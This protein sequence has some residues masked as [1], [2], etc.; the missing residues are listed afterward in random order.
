[1]PDPLPKVD[2][3]IK[4]FIRQRCLR[5]L[6]SSISEYYPG[7]PVN[8]A[9]DSKIDDET[10]AYYAGLE[11]RGDRVLLLP[12]NVGISAGRNALVDITSRP[13][14]LFL[15]DDVVFFDETR[16]RDMVDVLDADPS[17]GVAGGSL[18]DNGTDLLPYEHNV[19]L[20]DRV[21]HYYPVGP[22]STVIG[23]HPCR[24]ADVVH[25]FCL[26]RRQVFDSTR[27]DEELKMAE[28]T[29]FF[30]RLKAAGWKAVHVGG[31]SVGHFRE[32]P[33]GYE[34]FRFDP[35]NVKR[36]MAKWHM[37]G[38][39]YHTG[40]VG[41]DRHEVRRLYAKS[42]LASLREHRLGEAA[43]TLTSALVAEAR[44]VAAGPSAK[45]Q[46]RSA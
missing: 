14:L 38:S 43:G 3:C 45:G 17:I 27:W 21:L 28:H 34:N 20:K 35:E 22:E 24:W 8:I 15:D 33:E 46:R 4:T 25:N 2:I 39:I 36:V 31:V 10:R 40:D 16:I 41:K 37:I 7:A 6:V 29:D 30:L 9:D 13:Y 44:Q 26:V 18:I 5:R 23:G 11:Q 42:A 1:M 32:S 12:Y 19:R